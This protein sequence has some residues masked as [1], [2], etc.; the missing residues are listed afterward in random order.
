MDATSRTPGLRPRRPVEPTLSAGS[1][2]KV[3]EATSSTSTDPRVVHAPQAP[4]QQ[5][6][7]PVAAAVLGSGNTAF[8]VRLGRGQAKASGLDHPTFEAQLDQL[9]QSRARPDNRVRP[10]F[11]GSASFAER[12]RLIDAAQSSIHLQTFVFTDDDTGWDLARRLAAKASAG[13]E[14]RVIADGVGS[15]RTDAKLFDFMR[16]AGVDVRLHETGLNLLAVN[17]RWHEKHFIVDGKVTVE[18]G[19]NIANEYAFGG[20]GR[21]VFFD[22][23][24]ST[25]AWRDVDVRVEGPAVHDVQ[26]AFLRNWALLGDPVP[27][28]SM[29]ALFPPPTRSPG[30]ATVRA[31]QHHPH[32]DPPDDNTLKLYLAAIN[33]ATKSIEIENAYFI[34]PAALRQALCDAAQRGVHVRVL[35]NSKES[36]NWSFVCDAA[37]WFYD[38]MIAAGV[39]IFEKEAGGTLHSKTA[40]FDGHYSIIGSCNLNGRSDGRDT[41]SV[42]AIRDEHTGAALQERFAEG[43]TEAKQVTAAELAGESFLTDVKQWAMS[44]L[45]WTL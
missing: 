28:S 6:Q 23:K 24:P 37:R 36:S 4:R 11:D 20:S 41:E 31:V 32:G 21:Q 35:T 40:S 27:P 2:A 29:A 18:G 25:E 38:D 12:D 39:E 14:V 3:A 22:N 43:L 15:N 33:A 42:V 30:G 7:A 17:D 16:A 34:P 8:D 1:T 45:A 13:V 26:R 44:T 10:L 5:S 9:T 19:M